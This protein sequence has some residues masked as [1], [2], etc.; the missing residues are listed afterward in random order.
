[1]PVM[2]SKAADVFA[3]GIFAAELFTGTAPFETETHVVAAQN[4][5]K[6]KRPEMPENA[7]K[8]GLT[9][10]IWKLLERCW[11]QKPKKRP[12]MEEVVR[13]WQGFVGNNVDSN[14]AIGYVRITRAI[15]DS[16]SVPFSTSVIDL[17]VHHPRQD[18]HRDDELGPRPSNL[19]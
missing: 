9:D 4:H 5:G 16:S 8:G 7:Q 13:R 12:T 1:M 17:G 14:G 2:E 18:P 6:G 15:R 3:F 11:E 19:Y 10:E